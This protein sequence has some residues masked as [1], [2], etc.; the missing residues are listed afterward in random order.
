MN[1]NNNQ[2][3]DIQRELN[4]LR[5]EVTFLTAE[6][7][8][9]MR[10]K[11]EAEIFS[12]RKSEFLANMSHE[13]RTPMHAILSFS[14]MSLKKL[15]IIERSKLMRNIEIIYESG[16]RLLHTLNDVLDISK[17]E[18]GKMDFDLQENDLLK[19]VTS[20]VQEL[21]SL[22][23]DKGIPY[24]ISSDNTDGTAF[25]DQHKIGQVLQNIIGNAIKFSPNEGK[26]TIRTAGFEK[27][28]EKHLQVSVCNEGQS[29]PASE[30]NVI[31]DK[32]FQSSAKSAQVGGTGLGLS[33]AK[34]II[35]YHKGQI[36][37]ESNSKQTK[38]HFTLPKNKKGHYAEY[39][40]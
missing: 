11:L 40:S 18:S 6:N 14:K 9:L 13:L 25:F 4:R 31:F 8:D 37:A 26:V 35:D 17:L 24:D 12:K 20:V 16:Q 34:Q 1:N 15:G 33:I 5:E 32:Y 36:W 29:I 27:D 10:A 22:M 21:Q 23:L 2:A 28:E 39:I 38:F 30:L 3:F 7:E 19:E